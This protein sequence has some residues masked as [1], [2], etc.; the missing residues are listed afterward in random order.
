MGTSKITA[1]AISTIIQGV[2]FQRFFIAWPN[3]A[4]Q[5][6]PIC[7]GPE[8]QMVSNNVSIE[9]DRYYISDNSPSSFHSHYSS[10]FPPLDANKPA[11]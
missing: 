4:F 1:F 11:L 3:G 10:C 6:R 9:C 2:D 8:R 7:F 5:F